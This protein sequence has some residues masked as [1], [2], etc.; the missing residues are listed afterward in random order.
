MSYDPQEAGLACQYCTTRLAVEEYRKMRTVRPELTDL[1]RELT[2]K[3]QKIPAASAEEAGKTSETEQKPDGT[4]SVTVFTCPRCGAALMSTRETAATFCSYCGSSVALEGQLSR[5]KRPDWIIPFSVTGEQCQD[6][7]R[8]LLESSFF[9]P[10]EMKK[11]DQIEKFRGIY[12]PYWI[13][14]FRQK[15]P[16]KLTGRK[17]ETKGDIEKTKYYDIRIPSEAV[18]E[19]IAFDS[20]SVFYDNLSEG[21][22][23]FVPEKGTAFDP[24]YISG[25]YADAGDL[26][27]D[28]YMEKAR[29]MAAEVLSKQI[30]EGCP[31]RGFAVD[32]VSIENKLKLE[33]TTQSGLFPVW[34]LATRIRQK[35]GTEDRIFY[36]V[37]NG[38]TGKIYADLPIDFKK[39]FAGCLLLAVP[40]YLFLN[41]I[42]TPT[43]TRMLIAAAVLA[44]VGIV[45]SNRQIDRIGRRE[46]RM[47]DIGQ[48]VANAANQERAYSILRRKKEPKE[49]I[50]SL[51]DLEV[52][53]IVAL[54]LLLPFFLMVV[55]ALLGIPAMLLLLIFVLVMLGLVMWL[56]EKGNEKRKS[57]VPI[58]RKLSACRKQIIGL[59][60]ILIV[61]LARPVS[62]LYYYG[63]AFV[64][65]LLTVWSFYTIVMEYNELAARKIPQFGKRGERQG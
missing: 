1:D 53:E 24:A 44:F 47:D 15:G 43:P 63:A 45:L 54:F 59:A 23:P 46:L 18:C 34:F 33:L 3:A 61:L 6:A 7:Y 48:T 36:A 38:Q 27:T 50:F 37:V 25:Y 22:A 52:L 58:K 19:G 16:V 55:I 28:A 26:K 14:N 40:I 56:G 21:I 4:F 49:P 30:M 12:M 35:G 32:E 17:V 13:Y 29:S 39:Y 41:L 64:S 9:V 2:A 8:K 62:D 57:V 5:E 20:S 60:L 42:F 10:S 51:K 65:M 11:Q 31:V